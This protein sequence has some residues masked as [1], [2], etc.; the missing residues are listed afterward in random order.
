MVRKKRKHGFYTRLVL[1]LNIVAAI[2]LA[3]GYS[4]SLI[5]PYYFWPPALLG[6][7]VPYLFALNIGFA[8]FWI[9]R[10]RRWFLLS[11]A[12]V[13]IGL[14]QLQRYFAFN[15]MVELDE[16][17]PYLKVSTYN[18][19]NLS[20]DNISLNND[21][22]RK[23]IFEL[24]G[25]IDPDVLC[26]QEFMTS[27]IEPQKLFDSLRDFTGMPHYRYLSYIQSR[28]Q[29]N[30]IDAIVTYSKYPIVN[31][32]QVKKDELRNLALVTDILIRG[33][34]IR[35]YNVHLES[36]HLQQQDYEFISTMPRPQMEEE[37]NFRERTWN[38]LK[39]MRRAFRKRALQAQ[40]LSEHIQASPHPVILCGDFNDTPSSFAYSKLAGHLDDAY[41]ESGRGTGNTYAGSAPSYRIDYILYD[42]RFIS[43]NYQTWEVDLSDHYM[44]STFLLPVKDKRKD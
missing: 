32:F 23:G 16:G 21:T 5:N 29:K 44:I 26:M 43:Y 18:V 6:L 17:K 22:I 10:W 25:D 38:I 20:N 3:G 14:P 15:K 40:M 7:L 24:V 30:K 2:L 42:T 35:V 39:K 37:G 9:I 33:D 28:R 41:T 34:T 8:L 12:V 19:K 1:I 31:S 36:L 13:L 11:T 27:G 4:A